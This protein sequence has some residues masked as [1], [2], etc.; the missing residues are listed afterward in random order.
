[1]IEFFVKNGPLLAVPLLLLSV[2]RALW[3]WYLIRFG[4]TLVGT[5]SKL[6]SDADGSITPIV[7][8]TTPDQKNYNFRVQTVRGRDQW[9][10]G[11]TRNVRYDPRNPSRAQVDEPFQRWFPVILFAALGSFILVLSIVLRL[12]PSQTTS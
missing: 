5:V 4:K 2:F 1:M 8:F 11:A 9:T 7:S 10:I 6:D 12:L 3:A